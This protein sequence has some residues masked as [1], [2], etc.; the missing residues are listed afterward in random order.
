MVIRHLEIT[1]LTGGSVG[2][3]NKLL[4]ASYNILLMADL[5]S[6]YN[7]R[8][9]TLAAIEGERKTLSYEEDLNDTREDAKNK[10]EHLHPVMIPA[11]F[12]QALTPISPV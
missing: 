6:V 2:F 11:Q 7:Q 3:S 4:N 5:T 9:P 1:K 12:N 10:E 8:V